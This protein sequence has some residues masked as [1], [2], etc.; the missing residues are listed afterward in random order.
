MMIVTYFAIKL[1]VN[2]YQSITGLTYNVIRCLQLFLVPHKAIHLVR[3][4]QTVSTIF[5]N[6]S[7]PVHQECASD[8]NHIFN[9]EVQIL[10]YIIV[11][12]TF[13]LL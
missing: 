9:K 5:Q 2:A 10:L 12:L 8:G 4:Y 11:L 1:A 3:Y 7:S 6:I 13:N